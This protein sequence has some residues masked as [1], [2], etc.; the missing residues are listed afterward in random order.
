MTNV[1]SYTEIIKRHHVVAP[2][3]GGVLS[4][5]ELAAHWARKGTKSTYDDAARLVPDDENVHIAWDEVIER[6]YASEIDHFVHWL[7]SNVE[8]SEYLEI[9]S[10]IDQWRKAPK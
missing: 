4:D 3:E 7:G 10:F 9:T 5:L 8:S 6:D 2:I 1:R